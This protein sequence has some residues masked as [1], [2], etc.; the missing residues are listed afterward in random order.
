MQN[1]ID[2]SFLKQFLGFY[3]AVKIDTLVEVS[4]LSEPILMQKV[5]SCII[6]GEIDFKIDQERRCLVKN[7]NQNSQLLQIFEKAVV[8]LETKN[9][10]KG[11]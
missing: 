6:R 4:K 3:S 9:E 1:M 11:L 2:T 5:T 8:L 10:K 7:N